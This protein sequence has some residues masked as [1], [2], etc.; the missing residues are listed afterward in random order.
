MHLENDFTLQPCQEV[1]VVLVTPVLKDSGLWWTRSQLKE[2]KKATRTSSS[3]SLGHLL[4]GRTSGEDPQDAPP[5]SLC[6]RVR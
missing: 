2:N 6:S 1:R 5:G 4:V 3:S